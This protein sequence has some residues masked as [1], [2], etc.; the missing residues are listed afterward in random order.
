MRM[1][2]PHGRDDVD[3]YDVH[4]AA[5]RPV[6][7]GRPWL[8][9]DMV[10]SV[11]GAI[12]VDGKARGLA[13]ASDKAVFDALRAIA[14]VVLVAAGTARVERYGPARIAAE[15]QADRVAAGQGPAPPIAVVTRSLD[16]DLGSR[17]FTES[18]PDARPIVIT[19]T[20]ADPSR[21]DQVGEVAELVL[22]GEGRVDLGSALTQL[23]ERGARVVTCEGGPTLNG[24]LVAD[25]LVDELDVSFSPMLVG[26]TGDPGL[27][28]HPPLVEPTP[29]RLAHLL[30]DDDGYTFARYLVDR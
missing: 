29:L 12:S 3:P 25:G 2:L 20:D 27:L 6:P 10:V 14:D 9:L 13:N 16:L 11:D 8:L 17:L 5:D 22:A 7:T 26:G 1:L 21:L 30:A 23:G 28:G 4:R 24:Q 18:I 19:T 15:R